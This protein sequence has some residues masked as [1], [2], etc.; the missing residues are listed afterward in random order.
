[1][2]CCPK[3]ACSAPQPGKQGTVVEHRWGSDMSRISQP[4]GAVMVPVVVLSWRF[5]SWVYP[6]S[7]I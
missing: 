7:L 3:G 6:V 2:G 4:S 1:M 5:I